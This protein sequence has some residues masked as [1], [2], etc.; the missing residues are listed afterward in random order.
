MFKHLFITLLTSLTIQAWYRSTQRTCLAPRQLGME[1]SRPC[2]FF[3]LFLLLLNC[4]FLLRF[5]VLI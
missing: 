4:L 5:N 1:S 2:N 3:I